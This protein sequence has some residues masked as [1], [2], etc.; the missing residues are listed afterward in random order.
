M[1]RKF[2]LINVR[3][4]I[5]RCSVKKGVLGKFTK[6]DRETPVLESFF[7]KVAGEACNFM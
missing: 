3:N 5:E 1:N 4:V 6:I 2:L 7:N